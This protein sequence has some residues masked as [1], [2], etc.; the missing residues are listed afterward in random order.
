MLYEKQSGSHTFVAIGF[1][2]DKQIQ[3]RMGLVLNFPVI[4]IL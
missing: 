3:V 2:L 1:I 4:F